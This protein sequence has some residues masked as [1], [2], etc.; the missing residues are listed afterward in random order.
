MS[1]SVHIRANAQPIFWNIQV[2]EG[3]HSELPVAKQAQDSKGRR[4]RNS[5]LR[6]QLRLLHGSNF[7]V[8]CCA[9]ELDGESLGT[10]IDLSKEGN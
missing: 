8:Q 6:I 10:R 3:A 4:E 2:G 9:I 5:F 1:F 7:A